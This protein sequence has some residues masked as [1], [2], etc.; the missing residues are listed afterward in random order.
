M[1]DKKNELDEIPIV[2][3]S[4]IIDGNILQL[5]ASLKNNTQIDITAETKEDSRNLGAS[6]T[7]TVIVIDSDEDGIAA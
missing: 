7:K 4:Q 6:I 2:F 5:A 3:M 1:S